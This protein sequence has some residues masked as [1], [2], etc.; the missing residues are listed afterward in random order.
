M[1]SRKDRLRTEPPPEMIDHLKIIWN[2]IRTQINTT[3]NVA[4]EPEAH[5]AFEDMDDEMTD[6]INEGQAEV[7][8]LNRAHINAARV[9]AALAVGINQINPIITSEL[10][11]WAR[12]FVLKGYV[13]C[14]RVM[15]EGEA[16]SG[17]RVRVAK[18]KKAIAD[19]I[20]M[21][22]GRRLSTYRVPRGLCELDHVICERYFIEKLSKLPDFK[23]SDLGLSSEDLVRKTITEMIRQEYLYEIDRGAVMVQFQIDISARTKQTL[24]AIGPS[25]GA[26]N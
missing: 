6:R 25:F 2:G 5:K 10:F 8:L 22:P 23:G 15:S 13:E 26:E 24:Y 11:Q 3:T 19:Y 17:E 16:G 20:K 4:W 21:P 1:H 9:A 18:V 14:L 12:A 7:D